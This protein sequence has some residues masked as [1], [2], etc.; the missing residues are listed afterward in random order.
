MTEEFS[1]KVQ[2]VQ[3]AFSFAVYRSELKVELLAKKVPAL[4]DLG[5]SQPFQLLSDA[6][7]R[8]VTLRKHAVEENQQW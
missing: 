1:I 3:P 4:D 6:E 7:S 2:K 5:D 8:T